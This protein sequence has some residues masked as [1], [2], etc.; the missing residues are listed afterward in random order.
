MLL[1]FDS[2]FLEFCQIDA[3]PGIDDG[4]LHLSAHLLYRNVHR[5]S[6]HF[7]FKA[8]HHGIL[9]KGLDHQRGKAQVAKLCRTVYGEGQPLLEPELLDGQILAYKL[10]LFFQGDVI[11]VLQGVPEDGCEAVDEVNGA[12]GVL[13]E[14]GTADDVQGIEEEVRV[15]LRLQCFVAG[16]FQLPCGSHL[17]QLLVM[18]RL[19]QLGVLLDHLEPFFQALAHLVHA[20]LEV[21]QFIR[22]GKGNC[23]AFEFPMENVSCRLYHLIDGIHQTHG[24]L[25]DG[26]AVSDCNEEEEENSQGTVVEDS[27]TG[28]LHPVHIG[29]DHG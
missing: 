11:M 25:V 28:F 3:H 16:L 5:A 20:L 2:L 29:F 8:V 23:R 14:S 27:L 12:V 19:L 24:H 6:L 13:K 18:D 4:D 15:D 21:A 1:A 7:W 10:Q 9:D 26:N 17:F 22:S